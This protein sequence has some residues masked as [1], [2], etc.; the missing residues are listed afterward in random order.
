MLHTQNCDWNGKSLIFNLRS[1]CQYFQRRQTEALEGWF[2]SAICVFP[3]NSCHLSFFLSAA[4]WR[5]PQ[6]RAPQGG[7][8]GRLHPSP[9]DQSGSA[10]EQSS[11]AL[12]RGSGYHLPTPASNCNFSVVEKRDSSFSEPLSAISR[13]CRTRQFLS[14]RGSRRFKGKSLEPR[15]CSM[16][17]MAGAEESH[18]LRFSIERHS[19]ASFSEAEGCWIELLPISFW[20]DEG[21]TFSNPAITLL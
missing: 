13:Q 5:L 7:S 14:S 18:L 6:R 16:V 11:K 20:K 3:H 2:Q 4:P 9:E 1:Y 17:Y 21:A 10:I 19:F 12:S 15:G 8:A